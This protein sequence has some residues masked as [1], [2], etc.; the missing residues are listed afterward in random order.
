MLD[1][2]SCMTSNGQHNLLSN[3]TPSADVLSEI[4]RSWRVC[5]RLENRAA[6]VD[7][8]FLQN[9]LALFRIFGI[10]VVN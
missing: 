8:H 3:T 4:Q 6:S 9:S 7:H 5:D 10:K 1:E 2:C